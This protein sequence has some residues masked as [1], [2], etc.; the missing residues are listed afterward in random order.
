MAAANCSGIILCSH[1]WFFTTLQS[2]GGGGEVWLPHLYGQGGR[3]HLA[4]FVFTPNT[5][6]FV[7]STWNLK[8]F[9]IILAKP[10]EN[11]IFLDFRLRFEKQRKSVES[12]FCGSGVIRTSC[13]VKWKSSGT[14]LVSIEKKKDEASTF[15]LLPKS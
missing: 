10:H 15:P 2:V 4:I 11:H 9:V 14:F 7:I 6:I 8:L 13:D 12:P 5:K 3:Y 1:K